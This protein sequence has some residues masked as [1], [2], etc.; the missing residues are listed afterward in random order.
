[1]NLHDLDNSIRK[2]KQLAEGYTVVP[3]IDR[4][5]YTDRP[6]LE[7]P[8]HTKTGKVV[9]YDKKEGKYYDPS[10]DFYISHEDWQAMNEQDV[11]E[12]TGDEK[13]DKSMRQ[14]TGDITPDD[15][16]EMWPT[17]EFEPLNLDPSY[18]PMMDKYKAKLFPLAYQYWTD[19]DNADELRA[20]G[21]EPD[22]GDDYV[23]V[24]LSG[25]GHDGH[26]Q[27][28]KYDF[29]AEGENM[30]EVI[31]DEGVLGFMTTPQ[32]RSANKPNISSAEMRK[33]FEKDKPNDPPKYN[34]NTGQR[35][36]QVYTRSNEEQD[37]D[38]YGYKS[39]STK[40]I[41]KLINSGNWEAMA[42]IKP[43]GH[44]QLRNTRNGKHTTIHVKQDVAEDLPPPE[45][46]RKTQI[47]GTLPTYKKAADMIAK[48]GVQGK[49]LD[50]GAGL[51]H[52]TGELGKD[53]H[54]Y[55]PFPG[56][57]FKPHF[58][59]VTKIPDN[60]Y[61]KIVNLNVLNVVPNVGDH[62]IRDSIVKNIGRVLAPGGVAI[63]TT[64]GKDVLTIK[65]TPGEEPMSMISKIGTY[66]KGFSQ[67]E[68][69]QYVRSMLGDGFDVS[70]VKLGPAGVMI[71]KKSEMTESGD[72]GGLKSGSMISVTTI[73]GTKH[74]G[75]FE[76]DNG[77]TIVMRTIG[78]GGNPHTSKD[79]GDETHI[80]VLKKSHIKTIAA[81]DQGVAEGSSE[82]KYANLSNRGV[83]RGIKRAGDDFN[84]MLDLDQV[85][86]P[87]YTTQHQQDT[88]QRLKTKPMAGPK[89]VLPEQGVEGA[90]NPD[91][92]VEAHGYTYNNR[93]QRM[94][95][96]KTF[97]SEEAAY[98]WAN[99]R[100]ATILDFKELKK[101]VDET[102]DAE[103]DSKYKA[104][105]SYKNYK[106][107]VRIQAFNNKFD[108]RTEIGKTELIGI[109]S[110]PADAVTN[111][112]LKIDQMLN[113]AVPATGGASIDFNVKFV[114]D[115]LG[116]SRP[117]LAKIEK[118]N[119]EPK[120]VIAGDYFSD[121]P[122]IAKLG[123]KRSHNRTTQSGEFATQLPM[124]ALTTRAIQGTGLIANGR[125][126]IGNEN[127]DDYDNRIFDLTY[128]STAHTASDKVRLKVPALTVGTAR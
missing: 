36:H 77:E 3:G 95:W 30:T 114:T 43:N 15:A 104:V 32:K 118:I 24:V 47:A 72:T 2:N 53:A 70:S 33:Y 83:N 91:A 79:L 38:G 93:D 25:I 58:I 62:K 52:G 92:P 96:T 11:A 88:K 67:V 84:R 5:R 115:I 71:K 82:N 112:K 20:L 125:Y 14:M 40:Q 55:E 100:N 16:A 111:V 78:R 6:G 28:D 48:T 4:E 49:A 37:N 122:D 18:L 12:A 41:M 57:K 31:A 81:I 19:G 80:V 107:F 26:I 64:R 68:L 45:N 97:S 10:S 98:K 66:Q 101:P 102:I 127:R 119:G 123:F 106:I 103:S 59:D 124:I 27:Y 113:A 34:N 17:Q 44:L 75:T 87:H 85:E 22:Y 89:G 50:F 74:Q 8:F 23:M 35:P 46:A 21:W 42:D 109:G 73:K 110:T 76:R 63:I 126:E 120:L 51:G 99:A 116:T 61:H 39:L 86:S 128:N 9:Y 54:S 121:D 94:M 29:D 56:E 108:A 60:T 13:F 7:G 69:A 1:M 117:F 65:G 90:A 105:E